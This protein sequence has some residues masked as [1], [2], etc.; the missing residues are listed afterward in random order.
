MSESRFGRVI[1][2]YSYKGGV[3]RT[4][5][6]ADVAVMLAKMGHRVLM[7]D[8]DLE[9]P[10]LHRFFMNRLSG[11]GEPELTFRSHPG[12]VELI[13][14]L[15]GSAYSYDVDLVSDGLAKLDIDYSGTIVGDFGQPTVFNGSGELIRSGFGP[16]G[17]VKSGGVAPV[18]GRP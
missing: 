1:T 9:A 4:L 18:T 8:W 13:T 2:F 5:A 12:L 15:D 14:Q 11:R 3:G 7:V 6:L 10:G 16:N 17:T